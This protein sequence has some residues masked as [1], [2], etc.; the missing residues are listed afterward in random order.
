MSANSEASGNENIASIHQQQGQYAPSY[1]NNNDNISDNDSLSE[2]N[3]V[4]VT[5]YEPFSNLSSTD[6]IHN[7]YH[8][9]AQA[10]LHSKRSVGQFST[11][12]ANSVADRLERTLCSKMVEYKHLILILNTMAV[13]NKR[14]SVEV[15]FIQS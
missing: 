6:E 11:D 15:R 12:L 3:A 2:E 4:E 9:S 7:R 13:L 5:A 1:N 10:S 14:L 8:A